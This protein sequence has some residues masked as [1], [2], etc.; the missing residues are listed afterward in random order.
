MNILPNSQSCHGEWSRWTWT[1][2]DC[3]ELTDFSI[4]QGT[5]ANRLWHT[6]TTWDR[7]GWL[8]FQINFFLNWSQLLW[9]FLRNSP[10]SSRGMEGE[11]T[12][13]ADYYQ[14]AVWHWPIGRVLSI[15][16]RTGNG[17]GQPVQGCTQ[18]Q[19]IVAES[20]KQTV[21]IAMATWRWGRRER[22]ARPAACL[23]DGSYV[24]YTSWI[25]SIPL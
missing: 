11:M 22:E 13:V 8:E 25:N 6:I 12:S 16:W 18:W 4:S 19:G 21:Q 10:N 24:V 7:E 17:R 5:L 3:S 15:Q 20:A 1:D 2:K 14:T 23:V 9:S